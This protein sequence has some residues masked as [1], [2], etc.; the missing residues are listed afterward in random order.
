MLVW[1]PCRVHNYINIPNFYEVT[2]SSYYEAG[3]IVRPALC[4]VLFVAGEEDGPSH[5][6]PHF[7]G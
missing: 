4:V 6:V 3:Y 1:L 2:A 7:R 5:Q